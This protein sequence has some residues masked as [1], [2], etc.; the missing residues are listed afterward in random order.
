MIHISMCDRC[1]NKVGTVPGMACP[2]WTGIQE[3]M[4]IISNAMLSASKPDPFD[5]MRPI[6]VVCE[7]HWLADCDFKCAYF[8][9]RAARA[10][11]EMKQ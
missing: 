6:S 3:G 8:V 11:Q 5:P 1:V 10:K 4:R 7:G 9:E 2:I